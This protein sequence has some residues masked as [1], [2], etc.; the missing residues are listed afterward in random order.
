MKSIASKH[1]QETQLS[2]LNNLK[3]NNYPI[4]FQGEVVYPTHILKLSLRL[5]LSQLIQIHGVMRE[6]SFL[7]LNYIL[8]KS[9]W[10][11][12]TPGNLNIVLNQWSFNFSMHQN[13]GWLVETELGGPTPRISVVGFSR[14]GIRPENLHSWQVPR[15]RWCCWFRYHILRIIRGNK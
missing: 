14:S 1:S 2:S 12:K 15:W 7:L 6:K 13:P 11:S 8:P 4:I 10:L 3:S 9:S 5:C